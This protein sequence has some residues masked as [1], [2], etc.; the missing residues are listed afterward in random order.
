L[1]DVSAYSLV[2]YN[3]D[4]LH[5]LMRA[6]QVVKPD[7]TLSVIQAKAEQWLKNLKDKIQLNTSAAMDQI[8]SEIEYNPNGSII[9]DLGHYD[10]FDLNKAVPAFTNSLERR[11][12]EALIFIIDYLDVENTQKYQPNSTTYCNYFVRDILFTMGINLYELGPYNANSIA[13][14]LGSANGKNAGWRNI[15]VT[16]AQAYANQGKI[17]ITVYRNYSTHYNEK[18]GRDEYDSGHV[19]VIRP[20]LEGDGNIGEGKKPMAAQAGSENFA[21][22]VWTRGQYKYAKFYMHD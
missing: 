8:P 6:M 20:V 10:L 16:E 22:D 9:K 11:S 19:Q 12:A 21:S 15:D 3:A 17:V 18:T 2:V 4:D 13:D 14:W 7:Y 1:V 5:I